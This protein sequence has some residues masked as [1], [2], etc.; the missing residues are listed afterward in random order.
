MATYRSQPYT[1]NKVLNGLKGD[2]GDA[3][4]GIKS[5]TITYQV[6]T[7]GVTAPTGTW[8]TSIPSVSPSQYLWTRIVI[9]YTDNTTSTAY[10]VGL[11][12]AK[13]DTGGSGPQGPQ[14]PT[15]GTGPSGRGIK[16]TVVEYQVSSNGTT[17][18]TGTWS[19]SIPSLGAGQFMWTRTTVTYTDNTST[20]AYSIG[21]AGTNG[22]PGKGVKST[23]VT[24]QAS[25]SG[26]VVPT[27]TWNT[28]IP[29]V[30]ASQY[31]WTRT[32]I[33][34]TDDTTSTSYSIGMM[35]ATG[36]TGG[37]G[38]KGDT[39]LGV[40]SIVPQYYLSTSST[41]QS[42]GSWNTAQPSWTPNKYIWTRSL[43]TWDN[44]STSTTTPIIAT[45][46]NDA[47]GNIV[48]LD[49]TILAWCMN[50]DKTYINGSKIYAKSITSSQLS[51]DA[52][53]SNNYVANSTGSFLNLA[54]GSFDSKYLKW[55]KEGVITATS[56]SIAGI[57]IESLKL[58]ASSTSDGVTKGYDITNDGYISTYNK[59]SGRDYS[60]HL[61][62]ENVNLLSQTS[63]GSVPKE[64][65]LTDSYL[66]Y[67]SQGSTIG[68]VD[69]SNDYL[70]LYGLSGVRVRTSLRVTDNA[71]FEKSISM[72]NNL[73]GMFVK[74]IQTGANTVIRFDVGQHQ[75]GII[76]GDTNTYASMFTFGRSAC[77]KI[78]GNGTIATSNG[79]VTLTSSPWSYY[80]VLSNYPIVETYS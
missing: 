23:T 36:G 26:T 41:A 5:T 65:S 73:N 4:K 63:A 46:L 61:T 53:K 66:L 43:I 47:L 27:S 50:N 17:V 22:N 10:S 29:S 39:G 77:Y 6:S 55:T 72:T 59:G 8:L 49:N 37:K 40:K 18:P 69:S 31:L 51:T 71:F 35:G 76:F 75:H 67:K 52:I 1:F 74:Y 34:Y 33:T 30:G 14:G 21:K 48:S 44:N 24:Y 38:D 70:D 60:L 57:K 20:T 80:L 28:T 54:D 56:G 3:G 9:T 25:A 62:A 2:T 16:T 58:T 7:N 45:T 68:Y 19:T 78:S 11:M 79:V 64:M 12:G 42:G 15:G 13:G 32:V